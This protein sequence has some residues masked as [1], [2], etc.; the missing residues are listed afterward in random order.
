[1]PILS[2]CI[3]T[4]NRA[5]FLDNSLQ[6]IVCQDVF[7]KTN[8]VEIIISD[9]CSSD[10]T[11]KIANKYM[12]LYPDKIFYNRNQNNI[13]DKNFGLVL[14]LGKGEFLKLC[15]DSLIFLPNSLMSM[16]EFIKRNK[17]KKPVLFF[18]NNKKQKEQNI[19]TLDDFVKVVSF[20]STWIG[21]FG[22]WKQDIFFLQDWEKYSNSKLAQTYVLFKMIAQKKSVSIAE[23]I[24][25]NL[26]KPSIS[27]N[28]NLCEVFI[29]NYLSSYTEYLQNK[30]LSHKIYE[31][32]KWN[33]LKKHILP[34]Q[35]NIK[36]KF[37]YDKSDFWKY[38]KPYHNSLKFYWLLI[39]A[40]IKKITH[41]R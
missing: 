41:F 34:R 22:L 24:F 40:I 17:A 38:T 27:G 8:E 19:S 14:S 16:L 7:Q 12:A 5:D 6:S 28:Y 18:P 31:K 1:M 37:I 39:R 4:Y 9:N 25:C 33:V 35:F 2:I 13:N 23:G 10:N 20:T 29:K 32:E 15:N 36:H 26:Y 3:P 21:A 30:T 11:Q